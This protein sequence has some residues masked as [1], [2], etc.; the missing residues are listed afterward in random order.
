MLRSS[1]TGEE[2]TDAPISAGFL[3]YCS[4]VASILNPQAVY[5]SRSAALRN[6]RI[7]TSI[8]V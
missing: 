5:S 1:I 2:E 8:I 3:K 7:V 6:E 4:G